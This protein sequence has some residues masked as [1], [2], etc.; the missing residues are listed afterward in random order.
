MG[1]IHIDPRQ[2]LGKLVLCLFWL[3]YEA[4]KILLVLSLQG[5]SHIHLDQLCIYTL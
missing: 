4:L 5:N 3:V 2:A 1:C